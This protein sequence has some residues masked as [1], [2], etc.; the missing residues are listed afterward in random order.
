MEDENLEDDESDRLVHRSRTIPTTRIVDRY[1][2]SENGI[3][4]FHAMLPYEEAARRGAA[5][6]TR[7]KCWKREFD[8]QQRIALQRMPSHR[9]Y[10]RR[11]SY[12]KF[13]I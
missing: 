1:C 7:K 9:M 12:K 2:E 11:L 8:D 5:A 3:I 4:N 6:R 13:L 10:H